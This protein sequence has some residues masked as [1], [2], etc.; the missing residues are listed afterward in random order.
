MIRSYKESDQVLARVSPDSTDPVTLFQPIGNQIKEINKI[1]ICNTHTVAVT[2]DIYL[3]TVGDT[4]SVDQALFYQ[5]S[6]AANS[7]EILEGAG[8]PIQG[9]AEDVLMC[10]VSNADKINFI[11]LGSELSL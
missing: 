2:V 8:L 1:M 11:V 6:I 7:T 10:K 3:C 4:P 5:V 9:I